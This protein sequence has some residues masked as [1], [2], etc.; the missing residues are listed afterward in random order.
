MF[1]CYILFTFYP[2]RI[3]AY[4]ISM[5]TIVT[6]LSVK[7]GCRQPCFEVLRGRLPVLVQECSS[8]LPRLIALFLGVTCRS[9]QCYGC[10]LNGSRNILSVDILPGGDFI[11]PGFFT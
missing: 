10:G 7:A 11:L 6:S 3:Y 9:Y 8:A 4:D 2:S 5:F 1:Q